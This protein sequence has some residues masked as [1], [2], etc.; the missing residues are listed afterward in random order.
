MFWVLNFCFSLNNK[1]LQPSL[2]QDVIPDVHGK[3]LPS[4]RPHPSFQQDVNPDVPRKQ[5]PSIRPHPS[6]Q[7]EVIRPKS[8]SFKKSLTLT[9]EKVRSLF[10][11]LH[12]FAQKIYHSKKSLALVR[13]KMNS[14]SIYLHYFVPEV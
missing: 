2:Q 10:T 12:S 13:K 11:H 4:I 6:F 8:I 1:C 9:R 7:Q 14:F 5:L 3:Q